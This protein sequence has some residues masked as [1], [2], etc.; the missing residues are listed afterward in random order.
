VTAFDFR[1]GLILI[2]ACETGVGAWVS[3]EGVLGIPFA[4]FAAGNGNTILTLWPIYDGSTSEFT[5][6]L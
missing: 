1:S 6:R 2:S 4:L 5:N 3:G